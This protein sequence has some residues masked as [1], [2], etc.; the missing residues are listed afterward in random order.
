MILGI[1]PARGGSEAIPRK[2]IKN[3][4]G[5]PL[6]WWTI[7]AAKE[8]K[9]LDRFVVSTEDDEIASLANGFGADVLRRPAHL[10]TADV[11]VT[12]VVQHVLEHIKADII[13]LLLV[14]S[15]VRINNII[16]KAVARFL[17]KE[18]DSLAIGYMFKY[19]EWGTAPEVP[20]Q[21]KKGYFVR[22]EERRVGKE[23]RSR[24]S[25]YH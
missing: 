20:R 5:H 3:L 19:D 23:C 12:R 7:Q 6:I 21:K 10:A 16:D 14:T 13:V 11:T 8:S 24:W 4:L 2:N 22:S 17:K 25:P 9:L 18:V 1:I 15:P